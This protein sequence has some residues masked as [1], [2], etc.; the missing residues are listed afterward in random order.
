MKYSVAAKWIVP[1]FLAIAVFAISAMVLF[2]QVKEADFH[3]DESGWI[4]SGYY[5][6]NLLLNRDFDP[7]HWECEECGPW[8]RLNMPLGKWLIGFSL[9][10]DP[11]LHGHIFT[12]YYDFEESREVNIREARIPPENILLRARKA[13]VWFGSLCCVLVF[14]IGLLA[15]NEWVGLLAAGLLVANNLFVQSATRAMTDIHYNFFLL[16]VC[17]TAML[18]LNIRG[19]KSAL[20]AG[21]LNGLASGLACSIKITGIVI[22]ALLVIAA[23]V[24]HNHIAKLRSSEIVSLFTGFSLTALFVIYG[25]NPYLWIPSKEISGS[26]LVQEIKLVTLDFRNGA[27]RKDAVEN[28]YPLLYD[29]TKFPYMFQRWNHQM[30]RQMKYSSA[31]FNGNRILT[32]QKRL[33]IE[34]ATLPF[35]GIFLMIGLL[36]YIPLVKKRL[37]LQTGRSDDL[38]KIPLAFFL[39]NYFFILFFMKLNWLRYYLP[40][41]IA[42]RLLIAY[43]IYLVGEQIRVYV[44][45]RWKLKEKEAS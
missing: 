28:R 16:V 15:Y 37:A 38:K 14:V 8:G 2:S 31:S 6:T 23:T 32:I 26:Q 25:L 34:F 3:G 33:W 4:A 41:V 11:N 20:V 29:L 44:A 30:N 40:T 42:D 19:K 45:Q 17:L 7:T 35:E 22:G 27:F 1:S 9:V 39:I 5:Y 24:Y 12:K 43:G 18:V 36:A 10:T 13:S 21:S